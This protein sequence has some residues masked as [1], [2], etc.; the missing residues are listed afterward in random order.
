MKIGDWVF[1][2]TCNW[3]KDVQ[4]TR[5]DSST[6]RAADVTGQGLYRARGKIIGIAGDKY[7]VREEKTNGVVE[8]GPHRDDEIGP[9]GFDFHTLT[10]GHL[11]AFLEQ[12]KDAP[13][14][15]PVTMDLPLAFFSDVNELPPDHPEFKAV[16]ACQ[17]VEA[18]GIGFMG[19]SEDGKLADRYIPPEE[20]EGE[21]WDFCVR[22]TPNPEQC[23]EALRERE[24]Q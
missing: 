10:L 1:F 17:S 12:Y 23:Y 15:V 6:G 20:R 13:D 18:C 5:I 4:V 3:P 16:S 11:R 24:D 14:D 21:E 9:F 22:I 19:F 7:T 2:K 8:V